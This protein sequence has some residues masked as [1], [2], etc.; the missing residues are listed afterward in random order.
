MQCVAV[1]CSVLQC[2]AV[3]SLQHSAI[4]CIAVICSDLQCVAVCRTH[5]SQLC[6]S[7]L[8]C[9]AVCCSKFTATNCN[10]LCC[11][12]LQ[13][14]AVCR[15]HLAQLSCS[16]MQCV[17]VCCSKFPARRSQDKYAGGLHSQSPSRIHDYYLCA[18]RCTFLYLH[19][20]KARAKRCKTAVI[21]VGTPHLIV[22]THTRLLSLR[23][24]MHIFVCICASKRARAQR[25]KITG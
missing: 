18:P 20:K 23:A 15:T 10:T 16:V 7:V 13:C 12:D 3:N 24:W 21:Y 1:C 6:C 11:S 25:F 8:Q 14:V 5:L 17:A 4:H 2:A 22:L 19:S 9:V